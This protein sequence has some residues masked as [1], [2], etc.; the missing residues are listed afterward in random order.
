M[1]STPEQHALAM[2]PSLPPGMRDDFVETTLGKIH[3]VTGGGGPPLFL[4]HGGHGGWIHWH[5]NLPAL[6]QRHTVIAVDMP[7]FGQSADLPGG[8]G[9]ADIARSIGEA[10]GA[11]RAGWPLAAQ[12]R[13]FD[14]GAFSFGS[15][16]ATEL[17]LQQPQAVR[18]LLLV[19]PPALGEVSPEVKAIQ[20]RAAQAARAHGLRAGLELTLRELM[21]SQPARADHHALA[22][23]ESGVRNTR[24][25][26]RS[27]AR[28]TRLL[29]MLGALRVP[30]YVVL[31]ENDPHQRH[32]LALR[33]ALLEQ[34]L[35]AS[36]VSV[37]AGVAHWL[38]YDD[39][40]RFNALALSVFG[41]MPPATASGEK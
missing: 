30:A 24:F 37:M 33:R 38:Q 34:L 10:I 14:L 8:S 21:L 35:G 32:E 4:L 5:A 6:A 39:P 22:L 11:I 25:V 3:Y 28:A 9:L 18:S 19:N 7:G 12:E 41:E 27:L 23:L 2:P 20:A 15:L 26:S 13:R 1:R 16:V 31:G 36:N 40:E 29:P 17:A